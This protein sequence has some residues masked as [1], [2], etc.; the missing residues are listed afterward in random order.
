MNQAQ[1]KTAL[2]WWFP[3]IEEAG[4]PVPRTKIIKMPQAAQKDMWQAFYGKDGSGAL[5][6]FGA[7]LRASAEDLGVPFFLRTDQTSGKHNWKHTCFVADPAKIGAHVF[8][9][10]E[11]S[12]I[13]GGLMG[14]P[15][16]TWVLREF[17]PTRPLGV[18]PRYG[19]MPVCREFRFFVDD[20]TIR[21]AHPYWPKKALED[22]GSWHI[23]YDAL[24]STLDGDALRGLAS[25]AGKACG[26]SWAVDILETDR[27]WV[28]I[29]MA[30]AHKSFHWEGCSHVK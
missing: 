6:E 28:I 23:D 9:L 29:D 2:S 20:G 4:L 13:A 25:A 24:C 19:D 14:L 8:A 15:W 3:R 16:H 1:D 7:L 18:C 10:A 30:E 11:Y 26:G 12:E 5:A 22:G 17:L 27:G 21:C